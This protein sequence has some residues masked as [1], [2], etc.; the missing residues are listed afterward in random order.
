MAMIILVNG[1]ATAV[2]QCEVCE[3][4]MV[5]LDIRTMEGWFCP[6]C[7]EEVEDGDDIL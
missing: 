7:D 5:P 6:K 1:K 2:P 3:S 4:N